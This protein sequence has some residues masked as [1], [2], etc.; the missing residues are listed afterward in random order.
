MSILHREES[1]DPL[2]SL[3]L[4][5]PPVFELDSRSR[6]EVDDCPRRKDFPCFGEGGHAGG[7]VNADPADVI[8]P[9]FDLAR[10]DARPDL[11][12]ERADRIPDGAGT[13][14]RSARSVEGGQNAIARRLD[15][16]ASV[17]LQF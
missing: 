4:V 2:Y 15:L 12:A 7:D 8:A 9:Q 13:A 11:D 10:V 17:A 5:F 16:Q 6:D 1:P 3:E 14:H